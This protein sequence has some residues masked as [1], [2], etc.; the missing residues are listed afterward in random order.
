VSAGRRGRRYSVVEGG[1]YALWFG[2]LSG[3]ALTG[4]LLGLGAGGFALGLAA[5]L[6]ALSM[7]LQG[8][9][10]PWLRR[11][12]DRRWI[13]GG[14]GAVH[15][16]GWALGGLLGLALPGPWGL[17]AFEAAYALA[18]LA[19]AP[20]AVAWPAYMADLVAPADRA[21]YFGLRQ[22]LTTAAGLA[23][24]L[25]GGWL[26]QTHPDRAGFRLLLVAGLA[27]GAANVAMWPLHPAV[28]RRGAAAATGPAWRQ[29]LQPF[30]QRS[31]H[32][33][34]N[35]LFAAFA[36]VQGT[37]VPFFPVALLGPLGL[38][39]GQAAALAAVAGLA[40]ALV[41]PLAGRWQERHGEEAVASWAMLALA[42]APALLWLG[43]SRPWPLL[44]LCHVVFGGGSGLFGLAALT[45][46][47]RLAP[48]GERE[49]Y[50][51]AWGAAS[52]LAGLVGP[53]LAGLLLP[54]H[55]WSLCLGAAAGSLALAGI[56]WRGREVR[57]LAAGAGS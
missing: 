19:M 48:P 20:V 43:R 52:G 42:L 5:A 10:V 29:L 49:S 12:A 46:N 22:A 36:G 54:G 45:L 35:L 34:A 13:C 56:W 26:L 25:L 39:F 37:A 1:F 7:V 41:S 31:P 6:P 55:L 16:L 27:A 11:V 53:L 8:L 47:L 57:L 28:P 30:R 51:A 2:L 3:N 18:W 24:V 9:S 40:A 15:R 21:R 32:R 38:G 4:Y 14:C 17:V 50:L 23:G 44:L 33:R